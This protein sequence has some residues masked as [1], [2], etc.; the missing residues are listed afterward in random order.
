MIIETYSYPRA[1]VIGNP[2]DGYFGK[3]IAFVFSNFI[4]KVQLYQTPELEIRPER[5][6]VTHF[7]SIRE[8]V[9]DVNF[10][11]YYGGMRL[12]K[13]MIKVFYEYCTKNGIKIEERNFTIRYSSNIPLRLGLAGSSAIVTACL[14]ALTLYFNIK[15]PEPVFA[16]LVLSVERDELGISAGLQDR[17]AQAY[18]TPV[19]MNFDRK[20]MA[21]QGYGHY[22]KISTENFPMFY[23]AYRRNLSE[24]TEVVHNNLKARFEIGDPEVLEA[25]Q[26]W[27]QIT[28]EFRIALNE[29]DIRRMNLLVNEN[30]DLRR[31]II[32]IS[33]GNIEMVELARSVGA[34]AKFTGSG[35]AVIGICDDD[36]MFNRLKNKLNANGIDVIKPNIVNKTT[37][38]K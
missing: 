7:N 31:K 17:V 21:K 33:K 26:R 29:G 30:F 38:L 2:S 4:A 14:K 22:E 18:E 24:G 9:E 23:I 15:I 1:A 28:E 25:M 37:N 12:I 3:T 32:R 8:L 27:G 10:A 16:N 36:L 6:D 13:G 35:G 20:I 34:S 11:G 5:L 19:F